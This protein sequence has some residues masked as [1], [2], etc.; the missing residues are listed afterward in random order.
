MKVIIPSLT[1]TLAS[2]SFTEMENLFSKIINNATGPNDRAFAENQ[3]SLSLAQA[4]D[5]GCWCHS[6]TVH[7]GKGKSKP[8]DEL[9]ALC[10]RLS[11]GYDC[12]A[13]DG[14]ARNEECNAWEEDYSDENGDAIEC[15][16][17]L[18]EK[19]KIENNISDAIISVLDLQI[20]SE[21][22]K[23]ACTIEKDFVNKVAKL[24]LEDE[25][26][27]NAD[28]EHGAAGF[29][30]DQ[31]CPSKQCDEQKGHNCNG[32]KQCCGPVPGR[33]TYKD[34]S[35]AGEPRQCCGETT[36]FLD[37][38]LNECCNDGTVGAVGTCQ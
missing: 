24:F 37:N 16:K 8:L 9:D 28:F 22:K 30:S 3:F 19:E 25:N 4:S 7:T 13:I 10:K 14:E 21:C 11:D 17:M 15:G 33:R 35:D 38:G 26:A 18:T 31:Q 12:A 29:D 23:Q 27:R 34:L 6:L 1:F 2:A 36:V 20:V 32:V 5:Y